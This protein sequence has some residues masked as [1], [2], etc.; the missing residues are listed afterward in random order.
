[1]INECSASTIK[2]EDSCRPT[3]RKSGP[4]TTVKDSPKKRDTKKNATNNI[5]SSKKRVMFDLKEKS[6]IRKRGLSDPVLKFEPLY[7]LH[8]CKRL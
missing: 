8:N 4:F 1:M 6:P 7:N 2:T 5:I 3:F